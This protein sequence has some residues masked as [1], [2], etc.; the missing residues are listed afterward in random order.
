VFAARLRE[1]A[2]GTSARW[3]G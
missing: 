2:S 1:A 3:R